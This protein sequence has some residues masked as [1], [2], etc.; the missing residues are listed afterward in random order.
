MIIDR[1]VLEKKSY[2][3]KFSIIIF[4]VIMFRHNGIYSIVLSIPFLVIYLKKYRKA[5]LI[6]A[7]IPITIYFILSK[8]VYPIL[9]IA[10]GSLAEM[11]SIPF[12]QTARSLHEKEVYEEAD[13][14]KINKVLDVDVISKRYNPL[15]SDNVKGTFNRNCT[16][17]EL[18]DYFKVWGKYLFKYPLTYIEATLNNIYD[19]VYPESYAGVGYFEMPSNFKEV[20]D[21]NWKNV[22]TFQES[23]DD[24]KLLDKSPKRMYNN[25]RKRQDL[26]RLCQ[27]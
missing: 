26:E 15:L 7:V 22:E 25:Y 24:L 4:L 12:Q 5:L 11:L 13:I 18:I 10:P 19:F 9:D 2:L 20:K 1:K 21:L 3:I 23:R 8:I 27:E 6:C 14:E 16:T 17:K